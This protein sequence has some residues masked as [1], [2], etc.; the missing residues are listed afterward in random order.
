MCY[1]EHMD[2][3]QL[4]SVETRLKHLIELAARHDENF[5]TI[6]K[7]FATELKSIQSLERIARAHET[8]L[9]RL[10]RRK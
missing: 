1:R 8:R 7:T 9:T 6:A 10:E 4:K 3:G 2:N 5:R